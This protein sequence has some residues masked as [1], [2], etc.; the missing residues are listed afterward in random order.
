[1]KVASFVVIL[2][3]SV[4][5]LFA[6]N[7]TMV[8][9]PAGQEKIAGYLV[10]PSG[11]GPFPALVLV[12]EWWG[13][14]D[15]IK[16]IADRLAGEGY[17]ALAVDLYGGRVATDADQ[18]HMLMAGLSDDNAVRFL[19][20]GF[21]YLQSQP[22]VQKDRIGSIGWCMGGGYSLLLALNQ[23]KLAACVMFYGRVVLN[24]EKVKSLNCPVL[25]LFGEKDQAITPMDAMQFKKMGEVLGKDIEVYEY[26]DAGHGF[27]NETG[28]NYNAEAS[29]DAWSKTIP[30]LAKNLKKT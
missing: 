4:P 3:L 6:A 15:Q 10:K 23:P 19:Q 16:G 30:F 7:G 8:Q 28:K 20:S 17:V 14:N 12:H 29:K 2:L 25:G 1:V 18:A 9:I 5:L 21:D 13:L 26:K 24:Q 22:D 27:F 11:K